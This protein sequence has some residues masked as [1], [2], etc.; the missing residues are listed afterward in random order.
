[1][2]CWCTA[3]YSLGEYWFAVRRKHQTFPCQLVSMQLS[4]PK[5]L[6]GLYF[7]GPSGKESIRYIWKDEASSKDTWK[8][9]GLLSS[10][11]ANQIS[12]LLLYQSVTVQ[13]SLMDTNGWHRPMVVSLK[14]LPKPFREREKFFLRW[15]SS[16]SAAN[17]VQNHAATSCFCHNSTLAVAPA[18]YSSEEFDGSYSDV[19]KS[20][21]MGAFQ[22]WISENSDFNY[23]LWLYSISVTREQMHRPKG[24]IHWDW[25]QRLIDKA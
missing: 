7:T 6:Q 3:L 2:Y 8:V 5:A 21:Q 9:V 22:G 20:V 17:I 1:M 23:I 12:L 14:L 25:T 13:G 19:L 18:S 24:R 15:V 11:R 4:E 16:S 10:K